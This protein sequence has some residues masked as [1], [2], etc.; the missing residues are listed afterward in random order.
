MLISQE[1][2][3]SLFRIAGLEKDTKLHGNQFNISLAGISFVAF[4]SI[5]PNAESWQCSMS[6]RCRPARDI[7][8]KKRLSHISKVSAYRTAF[9]HRF[10]KNE[11]QCMYPRYSSEFSKSCLTV[12]V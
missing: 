11:R 4:P 9:Q 12:S 6:R 10:E 2:S 5:I 1:Y 8:E 3:W 7:H